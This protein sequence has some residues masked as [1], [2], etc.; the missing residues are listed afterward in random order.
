[1]SDNSPPRGQTA[2]H[3][4]PQHDD[5]RTGPTTVIQDQELP[6]YDATEP[7]PEV[8]TALAHQMGSETVRAY[9]AERPPLPGRAFEAIA[10]APHGQSDE[11]VRDLAVQ[12]G[13]WL[14]HPQFPHM[15]GRGYLDATRGMTAT[16]HTQ[17]TVQPQTDVIGTLAPCRR[18]Y[19]VPRPI[20]AETITSA[21][22]ATLAHNYSRDVPN[23]ADLAAARAAQAHISAVLQ[24]LSTD[25]RVCRTSSTTSAVLNAARVLD[26]DAVSFQ[27]MTGQLSTG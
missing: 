14:E 26:P 18:T 4:D 6:E 15:F 2:A 17:R 3:G 1:M 7:L 20:N 23:S 19:P 13:A 27:R 25:G 22:A 24:N 10:N 12:A 9:G 11:Q 5:A 8:V 16:E 21:L